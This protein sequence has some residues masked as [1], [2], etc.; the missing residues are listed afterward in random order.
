MKKSLSLCSFMRALAVFIYVFLIVELMS[1]SENIFASKPELF[2]G[3]F[4][5]LLFIISACITGFLVLEKPVSL[6]IDGKKKEAVKFLFTEVLWLILF[7]I[8]VAFILLF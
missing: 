2:I 7:L 6:Y 4:M 3:I 5:L 8:I 1:N